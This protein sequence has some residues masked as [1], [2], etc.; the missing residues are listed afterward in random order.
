MNKHETW[1]RGEIA[2]LR[3]GPGK[4]GREK[5]VDRK[6]VYLHLAGG[7]QQWLVETTRAQD[8]RW[9][10]TILRKTLDVPAVAPPAQPA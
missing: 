6:A 3:V 10:A 9:V 5:G 4:Q 7:K 2:A 8:M 1:E